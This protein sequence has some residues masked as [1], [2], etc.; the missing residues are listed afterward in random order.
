M[1]E[2]IHY[3]TCP[4]CQSADISFVLAA[5]DFTISKE[6]FEILQCENCTLRFTQ[7]IPDANSMGRYYQSLNYISHS[8]TKKGLVNSLYH[9][10]RK[11]T[12]QSKKNLV[13]KSTKNSKGNLLDVGAG[14]G[15]F[16]HAMQKANWNVTGLEPDEIARKKALENYGLQLQTIEHLFQFSDRNFDVIT[17]WHVLEH[18]HDLHNY[19]ETFKRILKKDGRLIIAVPNFTSLDAK[20]YKEF[21]AAYD[22][23]RHLYHFSPQSI[24]HLLHQYSF[25]VT[26]NKPMWF[27]SF[28]VSMLSEKYRSKKDNLV[29][30][31]WNG[32][33]SN[34]Y[35][36][37]NVKRCSSIIYIINNIN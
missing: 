6:D 36:A 34:L 27:D 10:V 25:Q 35:A 4:C 7:D 12:I 8:D 32:L 16:A 33:R 18:V 22:V 21:W 13:E 15:A 9:F 14:T 31:I 3:E 37:R 19:L 28:Y 24:A 26:N 11:Y 23:P 5:K 20:I 17:L 29:K 2:I 1:S 30:A